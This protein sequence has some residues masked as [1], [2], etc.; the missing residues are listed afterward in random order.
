MRSGRGSHFADDNLPV[1]AIE[2]DGIR[3]N[4]QWR[5]CFRW[6]EKEPADVEIVDYH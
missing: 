3:T 5:V 1:T 4:D 2:V 6:T